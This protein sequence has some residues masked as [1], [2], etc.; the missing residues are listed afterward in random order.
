MVF[1]PD[2][3]VSSLAEELG[4]VWISSSGVQLTDMLIE[5]LLA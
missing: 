4:H 5:D 1:L 2:L 3:Q